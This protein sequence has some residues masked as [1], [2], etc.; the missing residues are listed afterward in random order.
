MDPPCFELPHSFLCQKLKSP[1][2]P[3]QM[4]IKATEKFEE[5]E[6]ALHALYA[7]KDSFSVY[8]KMF[9]YQCSLKCVAL[10]KLLQQ[11][12]AEE[13]ETQPL[14]WWRHI[15]SPP[16]SFGGNKYSGG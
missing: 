8:W 13:E 12:Y 14:Q 4:S 3:P 6:Y 9:C 7:V 10:Q 15:I 11:K 2:F 5:R 16:P 1:P